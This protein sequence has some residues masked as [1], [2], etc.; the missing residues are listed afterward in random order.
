MLSHAGVCMGF[1]MRKHTVRKKFLH[2]CAWLCFVIAIIGIWQLACDMHYIP[3]YL[4]PSPQQIFDVCRHD[5]AELFAQTQTT[6][7][8]ALLGLCIGVA[9]GVVL[10]CAM[11]SFHAIQEILAPILTIS[12]TIPT[13]AL[14]PLLVLWFGYGI[15]PKVVLVA[16]TT[17]FPVAIS[18][19]NGFQS[20]DADLIDLMH[21]MGASRLHIFI[22]V[23]IPYA[24]DAFFS[25]LKISATYAI[26]GAVIAEWLGGFSGLGVYMTRARRSYAYARMFAAIFIVS[27]L[28]LAL[29]AAITFVQRLCMPYRYKRKEQNS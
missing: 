19:V 23:K 22:H 14:A 12:Q 21:T 10:A 1:F 25:G 28:S 13:V 15:L 2:A 20:I 4:L 8:E 27:L 26:V 29:I 7:Q 24:L 17:V 9:I 16:L 6:L 3:E 11:D 5:G 18:L